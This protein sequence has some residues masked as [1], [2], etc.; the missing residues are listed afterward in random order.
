[1]ILHG[2]QTDFPYLMASTADFARTTVFWVTMGASDP[3]HSKVKVADVRDPKV[4]DLSSGRL[5]CQKAY[6]CGR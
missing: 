1:M 2:G 6:Q 3:A 4:G 5:N